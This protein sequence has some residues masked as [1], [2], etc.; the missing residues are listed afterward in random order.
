[1]RPELVIRSALIGMGVFTAVPVLAVV[2][3]GQ[4]ASA[5]GVVE[6]GPMVLSLLQHRGVLQFL[7]GA[8]LVWAALAP[9]V[10]VPVA[11]GVIVAKLSS[12]VL[13]V[14]SPDAQARA[15]LGI[16]AFDVACV[17]VLAALALTALH[18]HVTRA[19]SGA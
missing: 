3:P 12:L 10:R 18:Q 7:A 1:M 11:L 4:L 5:Y 9:G 17:V 16:Q 14:S 8:A 19:P 2:D 6:P 15:S 13:T